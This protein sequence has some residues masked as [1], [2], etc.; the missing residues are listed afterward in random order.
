LEDLAPLQQLGVFKQRHPLLR[1]ATTQKLFWVKLSRLSVGWR[2]TLILVQA[3]AVV[4]WH[5]RD[6]S[7]RGLRDTESGQGENA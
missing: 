1:F 5:G 4:R 6:S 2:R 7:F 3:E